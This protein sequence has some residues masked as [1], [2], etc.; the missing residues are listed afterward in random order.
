MKDYPSIPSAIGQQFREIPRAQIFDKLDGSSMR[1]EWNRKQGWYKHGKRSGLTDDSNPHLVAAPAVFMAAMSE[2]LAKIAVDSR[3][4]AVVVFYE[5][6]GCKSIAGLHFS[7]DPKFVT[8]FDAAPY[9]KGILGPTEFR[10]L[11]EGKVPT[12]K[13]LGTVNW[14]RGYVDLVRKG[15][16]DGITHEGVVAKAGEKHDIV[17]AKAKTQRWIDAVIA[18]HGE[19]AGKKLIES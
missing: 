8:L 14:T 11:F 3:W 9:K 16:I 12:A 4:D 13:Y 6:W 10:K 17:R 5:F 19:L 1:A 7:G 18:A 2:T 15:V